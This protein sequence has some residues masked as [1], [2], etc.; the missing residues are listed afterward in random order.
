M[1]APSDLTADPTLIALYKDLHQ[2]PELGF[3]EHRTAGINVGVRRKPPGRAGEDRRVTACRDENAQLT[4][5]LDTL[6]NTCPGL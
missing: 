6:I 2:H 5:F 3:Q 4:N 1:P